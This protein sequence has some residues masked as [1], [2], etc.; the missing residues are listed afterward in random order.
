MDEH[1]E[2]IRKQKERLEKQRTAILNVLE[3]IAKEK[4]KFQALEKKFEDIARSS[5]DFLW[6]LDEDGH[7]TYA[8]GRISEILGYHPG[9]IIGKTPFDLMSEE[10]ADK[11]KKVFDIK[12]AKR[13]PIIDIKNWNLA[14]DGRKVCLLTNG[15]PVVDKRGNLIGYRGAD[16]DITVQEEIDK[17][18]SEFV[19]LASHQLRTPLTAISWYTE[20]LLAGDAGAINDN[21][22]KYLSEVY[23][24]NKRMI[25]LVNSLLNVSRIELGTFMVEPEPAH[26]EEMA[27]SVIKELDHSI[28]ERKLDFHKEYEASLPIINVDIKLTRMIFQNLLSNAVKYTPEGGKITLTIKKQDPNMLISVAD[29]GYGIPKNQQSHIFS[30]LFRADNVMAKDTEGTGL[31]LY[32]IKS[33][34]ESSGGKIWFESEENKGTTFFVNLP[35]SG[36]QKKKGSK[37]LS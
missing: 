10:E 9:E 13:E 19:S 3:D 16:K 1:T 22:K 36:M 12:V 31:G 18:K 14:K 4:D 33:I 35:L 26:L 2:E 15:V 20:M 6:E 17:A 5:S 27:D 30:K 7:Y 11:V 32:I 25:D 8:S 29:T 21:Q 28:K 37:P 34:V 23:D 24:G